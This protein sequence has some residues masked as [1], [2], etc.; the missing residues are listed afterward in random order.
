[1]KM[2]VLEQWIERWCDALV[3]QHLEFEVVYKRKDSLMFV[4]VL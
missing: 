2:V 4:F 3:L 1:M